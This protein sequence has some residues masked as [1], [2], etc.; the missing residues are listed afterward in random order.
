M[1]PKKGGNGKRDGQS[2]QDMR[3]RGNAVTETFW[4]DHIEVRVNRTAS[5]TCNGGKV[6]EAVHIFT[7]IGI[8]MTL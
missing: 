5:K 3:L 4:V 8:K 6:I 1:K 7:F 2:E